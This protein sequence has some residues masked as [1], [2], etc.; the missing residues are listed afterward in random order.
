MS[1]LYERTL[2]I[3]YTIIYGIINIIYEETQENVP[4]KMA[5]LT[6]WEVLHSEIN[7]VYANTSFIWVHLYSKVLRV[8]NLKARNDTE[9]NWILNVTL[10][11]AVVWSLSTAFT[12]RQALCIRIL[13]PM[14][15]SV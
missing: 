4:N 13:T 15:S 2:F 7:I 14:Q 11:V 9:R 1:S 10:K 8:E 3:T 12:S 6:Q 5:S